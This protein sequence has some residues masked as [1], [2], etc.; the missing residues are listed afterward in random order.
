MPALFVFL[1]AAFLVLPLVLRTL[2]ATLPPETLPPETLPAMLER[3]MED[4]E[5][6]T[7]SRASTISRFSTI[8]FVLTPLT[9][10]SFL[11]SATF[12]LSNV[13]ES[14]LAP[15]PSLL[16][17]ASTNS[18]FSSIPVVSMALSLHSARS[19]ATFMIS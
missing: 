17:K 18:S 19:W 4:E 16:Y 11:N 14:D 2:P 12:K 10:H 7:S 15:F 13:G 8:P 1:V 5:R 3:D 9:L 6:L